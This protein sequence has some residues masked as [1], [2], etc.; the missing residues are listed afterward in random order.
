MEERKI[1]QTKYRQTKRKSGE[2]M[3]HF[4]VKIFYNFYNSI[5]RLLFR[6]KREKKNVLKHK[7]IILV[8]TKYC[9]SARA[10]SQKSLLKLSVGNCFL[11]VVE[12]LSFF[13]SFVFV[14]RF[15]LSHFIIFSTLIIL[16]TYT[17]C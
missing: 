8:I 14:F 4:K 17:F 11:L 1:T 12:A 9:S 7:I 13:F 3:N 5:I 10:Q 15:I 6:R 16:C 2:K